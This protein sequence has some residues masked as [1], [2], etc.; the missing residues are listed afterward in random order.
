LPVSAKLFKITKFP[1]EFPIKTQPTATGLNDNFQLETKVER[2]GKGEYKEKNLT[3]L[4]VTHDKGTKFEGIGYS[5]ESGR[6]GD[7]ISLAEEKEF[8]AFVFPEND[9]LFSAFS[10]KEVFNQ[11]FKRLSNYY[12]TF[13]VEGK[14]RLITQKVKINLHKVKTSYT[15]EDTSPAIMGGWFRDL[16]ITNVDVA[17]LGGGGVE[18]SDDWTKYET[19]GKIS[20]LRLDFPNPNL[21]EEPFRLLLTSDG[22]IFSY[23]SFREHDFLKIVVPIFEYITQFIE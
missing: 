11:A 16:K 14:K 12:D 7:I 8:P 17:Y 6:I 4:M 1:E 21:D 20:A 2:I 19:S 15:D 23:K 22:S 9:Y 10:S 5:E 18:G 3:K 13:E